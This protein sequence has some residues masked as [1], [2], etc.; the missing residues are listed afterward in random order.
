V[1]PLTVSRAI[2][3]AGEEDH[4]LELMNTC[5]DPIPTDPLEREEAVYPFLDELGEVLIQRI[6]PDMRREELKQVIHEW[7]DEK[8]AQGPSSSMRPEFSRREK[9]E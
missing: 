4:F 5:I 1:T 2:R 6:R 9:H 3:E 8:I 7:I